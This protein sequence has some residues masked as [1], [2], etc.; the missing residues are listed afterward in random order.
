MIVE[1]M[2]QIVTRNSDQPGG[3][4]GVTAGQRTWALGSSVRHLSAKEGEA[5]L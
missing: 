1:E 3:V 4:R 2:I 5:L